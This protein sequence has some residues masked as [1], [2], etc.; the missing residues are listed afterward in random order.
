MEGDVSMWWIA[1]VLAIIAILII[2]S[3]CRIASIS[4]RQDERMYQE[5]YRSDK[6]GNN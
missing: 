3:L 6:D 5:M 2:V 1:S 4:D